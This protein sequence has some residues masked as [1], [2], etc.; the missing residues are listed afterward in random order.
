VSR[1]ELDPSA[2]LRRLASA[3]KLVRVRNLKLEP[4]LFDDPDM[5]G[6]PLAGDRSGDHEDEHEREGDDDGRADA[7]RPPSLPAGR[8]V[9]L[10]GRGTT[11]VTEAPGPEGAPTVVLLHG[12][13]ATG[14]LNWFNAIP[15]L[16][17][18]YRV[19]ALDH[20]GHGRGI[21]SARRFRL[22]DCADDVVALADHLGID[23]FVP[24]G[25]SMGGPIAQLVWRRHGERVDGLVLCATSR[26]FRGTPIEMAL[27]SAMG[28]LSL[29][30]R[31]APTPWQRQLGSR[32]VRRKYDD[33][34]IGAWARSEIGRNDPRALVEAGRAI[35]TFSSHRWI[36]EVDVP[37]AVVV[38]ERDSVVPPERQ[39]R[40]AAAIPGA[41]TFAVSGDHAVCV[42]DPDRF[43]PS[44]ARACAR[45]VDRARG[46]VAERAS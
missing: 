30:A 38:T 25:Y 43:V 9:E 15:T 34:D 2:R 14:A 3:R 13:T 8:P 36:G 5:D 27:F 17:R 29:A 18:S 31:V 24:V 19:V 46:D 11:W 16:A 35:G 44:L 10:E 23:R 22:E 33:S 12:W 37:T 32:Y 26:N 6:A 21:R 4:R 28:G 20:R 42:L 39:R 45:V 1:L 7:W 41:E 40:L